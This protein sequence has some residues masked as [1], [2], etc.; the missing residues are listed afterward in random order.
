MY[1]KQEK[2]TL[3]GLGYT[4]EQ[5]EESEENE[6]YKEALFSAKV[7]AASHGMSNS[8]IETIVKESYYPKVEADF[9]KDIIAA[10][11]EHELKDY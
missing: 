4:D 5:I 6:E 1:W 3:S 2:R 7:A 9:D 11:N 8:E 10:A